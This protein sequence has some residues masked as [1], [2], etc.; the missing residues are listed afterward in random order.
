MLHF[1]VLSSLASN[2]PKLGPQLCHREFVV[3][4]DVTA[5]EVT[6]L[7]GSLVVVV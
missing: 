5:I 3:A 2:T 1:S 6:P 4:D 7:R